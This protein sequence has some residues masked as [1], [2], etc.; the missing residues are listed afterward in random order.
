MK[1]LG[2]TSVWRGKR[3][4]LFFHDGHK[5]VTRF[6]EK[7]GKFIVTEAGKFSTQEVYNLAIYKQ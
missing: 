7:K 5:L 6:I 3:V 1:K 2:H 4:M